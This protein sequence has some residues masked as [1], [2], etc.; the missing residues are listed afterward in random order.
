MDKIQQITLLL[1]TGP[2]L[3]RLLELTPERAGPVAWL[4]L[5]ARL[6]ELDKGPHCM[7]CG[8]RIGK[9][10]RCRLCNLKADRAQSSA[11]VEASCH[12]YVKARIAEGS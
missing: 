7:D 10:L 8:V 5:T 11:A 4:A 9:G 3:W 6:G 2:N 12:D 1:R